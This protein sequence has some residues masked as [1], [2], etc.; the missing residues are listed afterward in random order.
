ML[1]ANGSDIAENFSGSRSLREEHHRV[2]K[3]I[4]S[5]G[6]DFLYSNLELPVVAVPR[7]EDDYQISHRSL[8]GLQPVLA[9]SQNCTIISLIPP[10]G[11]AA[12]HED[13][14]KSASKSFQ[15]T[16]FCAVK[17]Q[18]VLANPELVVPN[19]LTR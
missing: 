10:S 11:C 3:W 6:S 17:V 16:Q 8:N 18:Y 2:T 1:S 4:D 12:D 13:R 14:R 15:R 9:Q 7:N 5:T 19:V